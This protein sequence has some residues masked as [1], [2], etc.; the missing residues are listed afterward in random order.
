MLGSEVRGCF[1]AGQTARRNLAL[2]IELRCPLFLSLR[3]ANPAKLDLTPTSESHF[4]RV[5]HVFIFISICQAST[6]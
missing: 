6:L 1:N 5:D 4:V 3:N 2:S